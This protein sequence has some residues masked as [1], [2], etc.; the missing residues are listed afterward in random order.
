M[1]K[2]TIWLDSAWWGFDCWAVKPT[3][4]HKRR[5]WFLRAESSLSN[6]M[7]YCLKCKLCQSSAERVH[8]SAYYTPLWALFEGDDRMWHSWGC[9]CMCVCL[10]AC[11]CTFVRLCVCLWVCVHVRVCVSVRL[12]VL[13]M[14]CVRVRVVVYFC[15]CACICVCGYVCLCVCLWVCVFV[16]YALHACWC[17][18]RYVSNQCQR[19]LYKQ[20]SISREVLLQ[21]KLCFSVVWPAEG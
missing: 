6:D 15:V 3:E 11:L 1:N 20:L 4:R 12:C 18:H 7:L 17:A 5:W 21:F 8:T 10:P 16:Q 13:L 14:V 19:F 9:V 2:N